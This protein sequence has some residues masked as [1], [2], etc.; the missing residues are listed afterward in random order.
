MPS[1]LFSPTGIVPPTNSPLFNNYEHGHHSHYLGFPNGDIVDF[2]YSHGDGTID[3]VLLCPDLALSYNRP[4]SS[5]RS[6]SV[7]TITPPP[8]T[9]L[10]LVPEVVYDP[11]PARPVVDDPRDKEQDQYRWWLEPEMVPEVPCV[12]QGYDIVKGKDD[13]GHPHH[14]PD[15]AKFSHAGFLGNFVRKPVRREMGSQSLW[16]YSEDE[17]WVVNDENQVHSISPYQLKEFIKFSTIS[18]EFI[19]IN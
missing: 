3:P 16:I 2:A 19:P 5:L 14:V 17:Y 13:A 15:S 12:F 18:K 11:Q 4:T 9:Y 7:I 1:K 10:H 6:A 8:Q